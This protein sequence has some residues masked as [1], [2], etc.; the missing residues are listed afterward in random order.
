MRFPA[1]YAQYA[2]DSERYAVTAALATFLTITSWHGP[3]VRAGGESSPC[4]RSAQRPPAQRAGA[5]LAAPA[6]ARELTQAIRSTTGASPHRRS[7][8]YS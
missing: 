8:R 1:D 4:A 7:S 6:R 3:C 2:S 5:L